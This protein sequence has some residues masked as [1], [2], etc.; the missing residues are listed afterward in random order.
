M[1][2]NKPIKG[3][4]SS[5]KINFRIYILVVFVLAGC[6]NCDF[7]PV[8]LAGF[9][10]QLL[11]GNGFRSA[12]FF[13]WYVPAGW[14]IRE[15]FGRI[16]SGSRKQKTHLA[17]AVPR[18]IEN[19]EETA[20]KI[21]PILEINEDEIKE[22]W[23]SPMLVCGT[24]AQSKRTKSWWN[25]RK[26]NKGYLFFTRKRAILSWRNFRFSNY[27]LCWIRRREN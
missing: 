25:Q 17:Y 15:G 5:L 19:P 13:R 6:R 4:T 26:E 22:S 16:L 12:Q 20:K 3:K 8:Y 9:G 27:W 18:E 2:G 7:P 10:S 1:V 21:A 11:S 14:N 24:S 23:T